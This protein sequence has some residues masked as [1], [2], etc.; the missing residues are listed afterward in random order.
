M[1][2]WVRFQHTG[3]LNF[4]Y[5]GKLELTDRPKFCPYLVCSQIAIQKFKKDM[6][7]CFPKWCSKTRRVEC[8]LQFRLI[9][10]RFS[11]GL[12]LHYVNWSVVWF[13]NASFFS[14]PTIQFRLYIK[15]VVPNRQ[16]SLNCLKIT[17]ESKQWCLFEINFIAEDGNVRILPNGIVLCEHTESCTISITY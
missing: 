10:I 3:Q 12:E 13:K 4:Q 1:T 5:I 2:L 11:D 8:H 15:F 16:D 17:R 6:F 14:S 7:L 9:Y